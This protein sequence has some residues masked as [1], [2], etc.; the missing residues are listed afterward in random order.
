MNLP[1][2][3][4][5]FSSV[6]LLSKMKEFI[7]HIKSKAIVDLEIPCKTICLHP[8]DLKCSIWTK[9]KMFKQKI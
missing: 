6:T 1:C 8:I 9:Y 7:D 5:Q 2:D 4:S 3:L